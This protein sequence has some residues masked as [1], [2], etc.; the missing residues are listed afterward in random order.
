[1]RILTVSDTESKALWEHYEQNKITD[2]D[3]IISCGDLH[4]HYLSFLV[5][6]TNVPLLYVLGNHDELYD[7][8]PPEGCICIDDEVYVHNGVRILGLGGSSRY[9]NGTYMYTEKAMEK[10]IR[11]VRKKIK[12]VGGIDIVV[13]HAPLRGMGD[14][15]DVAHQGFQAF[16]PLLEEYTPQ[17]MLHGHM[18]LEYSRDLKRSLTYRNTTV[19]N[20]YEK[21]YVEI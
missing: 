11:N 4:P 21:Y 5:T 15:E 16:Y 9:R 3:L 10:R 20:T 8:L 7:T 2:T 12:R 6:M 18:H 1:M 14:G 19:V 17:Y 13:T